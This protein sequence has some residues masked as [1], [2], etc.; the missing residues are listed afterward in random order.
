MVACGRAWLLC[1]S[2]V[3]GVLCMVECLMANAWGPRVLESVGGL[4]L[5][6]SFWGLP[7]VTIWACGGLGLMG[8]LGTD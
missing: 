5:V 3:W 8:R 1:V 6:V 2:S 4:L 7:L